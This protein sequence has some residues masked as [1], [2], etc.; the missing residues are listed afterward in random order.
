MKNKFYRIWLVLVLIFLPV[1]SDQQKVKREWETASLKSV[2]INDNRI[3]E[4]TQKLD[5]GNFD[6]VDSL[7]IVKN[8]KLVYER[9]FR[10]YD[11]EKLHPV[12]SVTKSISSALIGIAIDKQFIKNVDV[13]IK[14]FFYDYKN[15]DWAGEKKEITLKDVLTMTAGLKWNESVP[16]SNWENTHTQMANSRNWIDFV[17]N[18]PLIQKPGERFNYNTGTSNLMAII[19]MQISEMGIDTFTQKYLFDPLG[20]IKSRWFRDPQGNPCSGGS[21]GGLFLRP[22]DMAKIGLLFLNQGKWKGKTVISEEWINESTSKQRGNA[23]YGYLWWRGAGYFNNKTIPYYFASGYGGQ[24]IYVV[25]DLNLVVVMTSS[26]YG[27]KRSIGS[28]HLMVIFY[29]YILKAA[30]MG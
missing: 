20:I 18:L 14:D 5:N 7:L 23:Q 10:G 26:Y 30:T 15:I 24:T 17:L 12:F 3:N 1:C 9:Y 28:M 6:R 11:A 8:N 13:K 2:G 21:N 4:L 16:Y 25:P 27:K 19:I 29:E 22:R